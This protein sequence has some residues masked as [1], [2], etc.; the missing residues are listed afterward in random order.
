MAELATQSAAL[1][2]QHEM[3]SPNNRADALCAAL[4][5]IAGTCIC[6]QTFASGQW[7]AGPMTEDEFVY[8][9]QA[10]TLAAGRLSFPSPPLPE[11][12][13][14]AHILV[15]P[16]FAAKYLPG[17]AAVLAPFEAAGIA[18]LAPC[19]LL[20]ATAALVFVAARLAGLSRAAGLA[21]ALLLLGATDVFP[22]FASYLSQ[23]TSV[24]VA[25]ALLACAIAAE[26]KPSGARIAALFSCIAFAGLVRPFTGVAAALTGAVLL[27]RVRRRAPLKTL[28]WALPPLA[29]GALIVA[30]VC[31]ATTGSPRTAPWSLY[32]RQYMPYDGPGIGSVPQT[33][34]ERGFP[35]HL[36]IL[37]DG[38]LESRRRHTLE[39]LPAEAFRRARIVAGLLP[40][41]A[42]VP[43][44]VLGLFWPPLIMTSV[45]AATTF[46]L[47]LTF[48]VGGAIYHLEMYPWLALAAA[49][50]GE[51]AI[52]AALRVRHVPAI[53]ACALVGAAAL[54]T[55]GRMV[56]DTALVLIHAPERGWPYARWEPA[57]SIFRQWRALVFIR[58]PPDWDGNADLTYNDPDL[59]RSDLVR[60]IDKGARNAELLPYFPDRPAVVFDPVSGRFDRIR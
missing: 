6:M 37:H 32:A 30:I 4:L 24:A 59:A 49:A 5:L 20:G 10:K 36:K 29:A 23:S 31:A 34:A 33:K 35:P 58:Y 28:A 52:R 47:Q 38:F 19:L 7:G 51:M 9:F 25:A 57:F 1:R 46:L 21:A 12:F 8:L 50:G 48:H 27:F 13:E 16:R 42:A 26:R 2:G 3:V 22:F 44:A 15:V 14:A 60:A 39:R 55:A 40:S 11:F 45:F 54:W 41:W 53:A 17:H 56:K 43:F 18:W